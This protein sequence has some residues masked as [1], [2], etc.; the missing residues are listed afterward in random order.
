MTFKNLSMHIVAPLI[1]KD[2]PSLQSSKFFLKMF[3]RAK[4]SIVLAELF[5]DVVELVEDK[6][7]APLLT[8]SVG[9]Y[10][11]IQLY[12]I[13]QKQNST[14][15]KLRCQLLLSVLKLN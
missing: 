8:L 11:C 13:S 10:Y 5:D 3:L 14:L 2:I 4:I 6:I 1:A 7:N 12:I 15:M 9:C